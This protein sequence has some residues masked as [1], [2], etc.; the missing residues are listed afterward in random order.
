VPFEDAEERLCAWLREPARHT[1]QRLQPYLVSVFHRDVARLKQA[2]LLMPVSPHLY[3]WLGGYHQRRGLEET[4][5]DP[6]D[7]I[8]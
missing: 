3:R 1:W 8:V 2:G 5:T 6:S 7:L 4:L